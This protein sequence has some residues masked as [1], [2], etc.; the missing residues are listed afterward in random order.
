MKLVTAANIRDGKNIH[1][2][3][4]APGEK[5]AGFWEFPGGTV[6]EEETTMIQNRLNNRPRKRLRFKT[7]SEVCSINL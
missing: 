3:R 4:R 6:D 7:P 1:V 5:L 2:V